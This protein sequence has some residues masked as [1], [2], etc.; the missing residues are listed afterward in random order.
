MYV[1]QNVAIFVNGANLSILLETTR[2]LERA[3]TGNGSRVY[4]AI[5]R[6]ED[7]DQGDTGKHR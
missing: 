3:I 2:H 5:H 1:L 7:L 4:D 6:D